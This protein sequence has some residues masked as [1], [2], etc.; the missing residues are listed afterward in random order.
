MVIGSA[1]SGQVLPQNG[2]IRSHSKF[3]YFLV[4]LVQADKPVPALRNRLQGIGSREFIDRASVQSSN[5]AVVKVLLVHIRALVNFV[6]VRCIDRGKALKPLF[7][8]GARTQ[9]LRN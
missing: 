6:V 1:F 7:L 5:E 8:H 9:T 4:D 3:V 2:R